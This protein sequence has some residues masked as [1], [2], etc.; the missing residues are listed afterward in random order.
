MDAIRE[1]VDLFI[2]GTRGGVA[3]GLGEVA[4]VLTA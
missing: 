2:D 3:C 1:E 4:D